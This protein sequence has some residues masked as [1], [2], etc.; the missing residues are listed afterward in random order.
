MQ[1]RP[2]L[3]LR[4]PSATSASP[5]AVAA[6]V[7]SGDDAEAQPDASPAPPSLRAVPSIPA[8]ISTNTAAPSFRR[9]SRAVV[10]RRTRSP[11][12]RTTIYFDVE[13][14]TDLSGWLAERDQELSDVVN[15]VVRD[16]LAHELKR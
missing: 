10:P 11:R 3:T 2:S 9:A 5:E 13:V 15:M 1:S 14:A 4:K 8:S 6:F 16:W 7:R 12:R